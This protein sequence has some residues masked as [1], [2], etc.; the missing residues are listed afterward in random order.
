M[1]KF[2]LTLIMAYVISSF[3]V[4]LF[5]MTYQQKISN[6][7]YITHE[8]LQDQIEFIDTG[9]LFYIPESEFP[10]LVKAISYNEGGVCVE[11]STC[12]HQPKCPRCGGC[13]YF[14]NCANNCVCI[15]RIP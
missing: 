12:R 7:V 6:H 5:G 10:Y 15:K 14:K 2:K 11:L 4:Q 3:S 9:I 8:Q 1:K 13:Y